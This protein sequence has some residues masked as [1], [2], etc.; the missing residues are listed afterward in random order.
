MDWFGLF[1]FVW[2]IFGALLCGA[3][4]ALVESNVVGKYKIDYTKVNGGKNKIIL[5][6]VLSGPLV[7]CIFIVKNLWKGILYLLDYTYKP[8]DYIVHNT[9]KIFVKEEE[10]K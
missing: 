7:W 9:L 6:Y 5:L 2:A 8:L 4:L 1:I 10:L 3:V